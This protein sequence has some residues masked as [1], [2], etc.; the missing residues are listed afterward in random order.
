MR[1]SYRSLALTLAFAAAAC[2][3]EAPPPQRTP[4]PATPPLPVSEIAATLVVPANAIVDVLNAKTQAQLANIKDEPVDCTIAKCNLDL[5]ATR[6]GP[7]TGNAGGGRL[8]LNVPMSATAQLE[9]KAGFFKTRANSQATGAVHTDTAIVLANDWRVQTDTRGTVDLSQ[10]QL[11]LGPI[12]MSFADLWNRNQLHLTGPL[13]KALDQHVASGIRIKPQAEK[14]WM[15]VQEPI[16]IG[17]APSAW[18]VLEPERV[19]VSQ[20]ATRNNTMVVSMGVEVRAHVVVSDQPPHPGPDRAL[21][22]PAPLVAP[23]DRF[24][25]VV[26]VLLPYGAAANL[27]M[28]HL[29]KAPLKLHGGRVRFEKLEILPSGEDVVVAARFCV[30]QSWD[31]FGWLDSCGEGYLRGVPQFDAHTNTIRIAN[32]HYDIATE[33]MILSIMRWLAGDELSKTVQQQLVFPVARDIERVDQELR[34]ALARPQG[35]DVVVTADVQNFGQPSLTWT[36]D[37][38]LATF[39]ASGTIHAV[40]DPK[41]RLVQ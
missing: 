24:A 25:F 37:G 4:P 40:L 13:F 39:P 12:K 3:F 10:A 11:K 20:P 21:P 19:R 7:I 35:R 41:N 14:L 6:T 32:V 9:M 1:T 23:S 15:K 8:S 34:T 28:Q 30:S 29:E 38:F 17:K 33:G 18:L 22:S 5:V 36:K 16:R 2:G 31:P 27:A 26:P